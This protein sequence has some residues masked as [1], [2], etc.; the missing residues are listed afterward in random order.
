MSNQE[1]R[2][3]EEL[4]K[5]MDK[6]LNKKDYLDPKDLITIEDVNCLVEC[7]RRYRDLLQSCGARDTMTYHYFT[8]YTQSL[9]AL[10][11]IPLIKLEEVEVED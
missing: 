11:Q 4:K 8:M 1:D 9:A 5:D 10:N 3:R 6:L 2:E 7:K